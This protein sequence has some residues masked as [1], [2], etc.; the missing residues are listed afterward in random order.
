MEKSVREIEQ[1]IEE[2]QR[3]IQQDPRNASAFYFITLAKLYIQL[4]RWNEAIDVCSQGIQIGHKMSF[5]YTMR[6]LAYGKL[7]QSSLAA[8]DFTYALQLDPH[9]ANALFNRSVLWIKLRDWHRVID[10][11]TLLIHARPNFFQ[12]YI[13]RGISLHQLAQNEAAMADLNFVIDNATLD[14]DKVVAST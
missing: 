1:S 9:D 8:K 3:Q 11:S 14:T 4:Q 5:L 13:N 2:L 12:A 10:D 7:D 6:G